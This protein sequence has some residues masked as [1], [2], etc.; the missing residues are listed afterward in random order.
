MIDKRLYEISPIV[1]E[2][3]SLGEI[4]FLISKLCKE[5]EEV[6]CKFS[7][8]NGNEIDVFDRKVKL[9][10]VYLLLNYRDKKVKI[11]FKDL[12]SNIPFTS[13]LI[14]IFK[15]LL[16]CDVNKNFFKLCEQYNTQ[17]YDDPYIPK[18]RRKK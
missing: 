13:T 11:S 9:K 8:Y 12:F 10:S 2:N 3:F 1:G 18:K 7:S 14:H 15:N 4:V 6:R 5:Y 17:Y 16:R